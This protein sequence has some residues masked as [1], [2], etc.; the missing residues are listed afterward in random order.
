MGYSKE[1]HVALIAEI[2][3]DKVGLNHGEWNKEDRR[4]NS[5]NIPYLI[6]MNL[7]ERVQSHHIQRCRADNRY[8]YSSKGK[9]M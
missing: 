2:G 4:H 6:R 7:K 1:G 9:E 5:Y 3:D 8:D